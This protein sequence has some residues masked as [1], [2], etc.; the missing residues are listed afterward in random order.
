MEAFEHISLGIGL[1]SAGFIGYQ[2]LKDREIHLAAFIV[3]LAGA[4]LH[5]FLT[6]RIAFMSEILINMGI[7]SL[8]GFLLFLIFWLKGKKIQLDVELGMGDIVMLIAL[9]F[10][11]PPLQFI[12]FYVFSLISLSLIAIS[13]L[14][15]KQVDTNYPIPLAGGLAIFFILLFPLRNVLFDPLVNYLTYGI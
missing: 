7:I 14:A 2:D 8:I 12:L 11:F 5:A 3:F 10:W 1:L 9:G 15:F 4:I 6:L 13:F